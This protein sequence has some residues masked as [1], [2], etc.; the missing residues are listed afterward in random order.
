MAVI[1]RKNGNYLEVEETV[2]S[3]KQDLYSKTAMENERAELVA[4]IAEID[5]LLAKFE[6]VV[7]LAAI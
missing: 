6:E 2:S 5:V 4:K 1:Y 3:V 7:S